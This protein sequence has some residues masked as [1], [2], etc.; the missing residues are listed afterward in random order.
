MRFDYQIKKCAKLTTK[1]VIDAYKSKF[2]MF[3]L[4]EDPLQRRVYFLSLMN[5]LKIVLSQFS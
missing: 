5:S 1:L 3:K 4:G 2:F